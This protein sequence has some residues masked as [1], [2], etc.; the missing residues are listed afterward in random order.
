MSFIYDSYCSV[1]GSAVEITGAEI[2]D[3]QDITIRVEPCPDCIKAAKEEAREQE[4][5]YTDRTV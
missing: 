3:G 1:C 2:D 5:D 4:G